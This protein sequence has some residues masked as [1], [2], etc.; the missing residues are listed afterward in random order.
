MKEY[1]V[2]VDIFFKCQSSSFSYTC[3]IRV[4]ANTKQQARTIA[5]NIRITNVKPLK[6]YEYIK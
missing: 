4:F 3:P 6:S 1:V 5:R 2:N